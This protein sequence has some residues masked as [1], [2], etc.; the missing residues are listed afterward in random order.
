MQLMS[1]ISTVVRIPSNGTHIT[2]SKAL[3]SLANK[4]ITRS[5]LASASKSM[6]FTANELN[7]VYPIEAS[8]NF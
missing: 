6:Y 7:C 5:I 3:C 1:S 8:S 2:N 4:F